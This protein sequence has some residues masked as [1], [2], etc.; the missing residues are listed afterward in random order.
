MKKVIKFHTPTC[1][2]CKTYNPIF[3]K[4]ATQYPGVE[5]QALDATQNRE[6]AAQFGIRGVPAT[7]FLKNGME[8]NRSMGPMSEQQLKQSIDGL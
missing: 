6:L 8:V 3:N 2:S 7:I 5:F 1:V 4:V